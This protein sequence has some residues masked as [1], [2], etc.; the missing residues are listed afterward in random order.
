M[1]SADQLHT[2]SLLTPIQA[3][4]WFIE[5]GDRTHGMGNRVTRVPPPTLCPFPAGIAASYLLHPLLMLVGPEDEMPAADPEVSRAAYN[6]APGPKE[7]TAASSTTARRPTRDV[8]S[9]PATPRHPLR[10]I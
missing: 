10:C 6:C 5:Y 1:V 4:R 7:L 3:F 2:P 8:D 9:S